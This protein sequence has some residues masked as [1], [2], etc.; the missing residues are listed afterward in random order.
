MEKINVLKFTAKANYIKFIDA[1][2]TV[3]HMQNMQFWVAFKKASL[4]S[5]SET[6]VEV[7]TLSPLV[8]SEI[9]IGPHSYAAYE[10]LTPCFIQ[11]QACTDRTKWLMIPIEITDKELGKRYL[12][13]IV[14]AKLKYRFPWECVV[15]QEILKRVETDL[16]CRD[17]RKWESVFCSQATLLFLRRCALSNILKIPRLHMLFSYDSNGVSPAMLYQILR[18]MQQTQ[19]P[20]KSC[21]KRFK[22][23]YIQKNRI[24]PMA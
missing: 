15:P 10:H 6:A 16:D 12:H 19:T 13:D 14:R 24:R 2:P 20:P 23:Y 9:R 4:H 7:I 17:P 3:F 21:R 18:K 1:V 8:H 11:T 5:L 22:L